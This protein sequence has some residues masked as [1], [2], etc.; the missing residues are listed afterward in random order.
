[1]GRCRRRRRRRRRDGMGLRKELSG[2]APLRESP[3]ASRGRERQRARR[4]VPARR[5]RKQGGAAASGPGGGPGRRFAAPPGRRARA[6]RWARVPVGT[7]A[8]LL[9]RRNAINQRR[10]APQFAVGNSQSCPSV[11][12]RARG[13][14]PVGAFCLRVIFWRFELGLSKSR[15]ERRER[16]LPPGVS[17][18]TSHGTEWSL[19]LSSRE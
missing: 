10:W 18:D 12:E 11:P 19:I 9:R 6:Q 1:V 2:R 8:G 7:L 3:A 17:V 13:I 15:Q 14:A 4:N 16:S 5:R